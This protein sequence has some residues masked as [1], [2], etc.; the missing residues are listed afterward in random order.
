MERVS[1]SLEQAD[2]LIKL[3][4]FINTRVKHIVSLNSGA[5][6]V[7]VGIQLA[8]VLAGNFLVSYTSEEAERLL[9]GGFTEK[10]LAV[11]KGFI[12]QIRL[13]ALKQQLKHRKENK[14]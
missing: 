8:S 2:Q 12:Q 9:Q 14:R 5:T 11:R 1:L 4:K 10:T 3:D 6:E 13:Q 7:Q